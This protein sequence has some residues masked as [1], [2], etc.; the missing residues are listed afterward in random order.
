MG[1]LIG[2]T[3]YNIVWTAYNV[4]KYPNTEHQY[5]HTQK[6]LAQRHMCGL[7]LIRR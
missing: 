2:T 5:I 1:K 6:G 7:E 3:A 4:S